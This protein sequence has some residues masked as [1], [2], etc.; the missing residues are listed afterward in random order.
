MI[1]QFVCRPR[2]QI[3]VDNFVSMWNNHAVEKGAK[4]PIQLFYQGAIAGTLK[5][6]RQDYVEEPIDGLYGVEFLGMD[7]NALV[8]D[9][10]P[11]SLDDIHPLFPEDYQFLQNHLNPLQEDESFGVNLF[12]SGRKMLGV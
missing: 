2:I 8:S 11:I 3:C 9:S 12:I 5:G 1:L 7:P 6:I 10:V 4:S